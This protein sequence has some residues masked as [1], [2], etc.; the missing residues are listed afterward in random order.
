MA[1]PDR[2]ADPQGLAGM[3]AVLRRWIIEQSLESN[4][5]HVASALSITDIVAVL[6]GEVMREPG[7]NHPD[8]D[9]F[10]LSKGHAALALYAAMRYRGSL[11]EKTFATF[12]RDGSLLGVH[13]EHELP[14]IDLSTGSLG[15]G[16]SVG[17]GIALGLK[18]KASPG[19]IFVLLSD[20]ELN[21]GAVWEAAQFAAHHRQDNLTAVIDLNGLQAFGFTRDVLDLSPVSDKW[22]AFGWE[23]VDVDGHNHAGLFKA[24]SDP[25][26]GKPRVVIARTVQGKGV[27]FMEN[28]LEWHYRNLTPEQAKLALREIGGGE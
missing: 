7:T 17:C 3:S 22:K 1:E 21:E 12:C 11:D 23:T 9:R 25:M 15:L 26:N 20:A 5:G 28:R 10:I 2:H 27:S 4:I 24:F 19:R 18:R 8:R 6:W 13:P 14:G 16:L